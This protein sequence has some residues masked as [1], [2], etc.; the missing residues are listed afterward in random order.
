M[1]LRA[2]RRAVFLLKQCGGGKVGEIVE[3]VDQQ[4]L[5]KLPSML[6]SPARIRTFLGYAEDDK[7]IPTDEQMKRILSA[8]GMRLRDLAKSA[9]KQSQLL[10]EITPPSYR[11]DLD[12]WEAYAEEVG[13]IH[14]YDRIPARAPKVALDRSAPSPLLTEDRTRALLAARG[15]HEVINYSF[16]GEEERRSSPSA[17]NPIPIINPL[18][19][20]MAMMRCDLL[21]GLLR[22]LLH[23]HRQRKRSHKLFEFGMCFIPDKSKDLCRQ[24]TRLGGAILDMPEERLFGEPADDFYA[25]K[26]DLQA[27]FAACGPSN[28][29]VFS[30]DGEDSAPS[31]IHP[32]RCLFLIDGGNKRLGYAGQLHP[33]LHQ[34][35]KLDRAQVYVFEFMADAL[36]MRAVGAYEP[37]SRYP[38]AQFELALVMDHSISYHQLQ[39]Q[40]YRCVG[41]HLQEIELLDIY[42]SP[43]LGEGKKSIALRL[44]WQSPKETLTD[45]YVNGQMRQLLRQLEKQH[46]HLRS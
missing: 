27:L 31:T 34:Q 30:A 13:R 39:Q 23:N 1:P 32:G 14:G 45:E 10:W 24:E 46:I 21:P 15:Y 33:L 44:I 37:F 19:Q 42:T 5:P 12:C 18:S 16:I 9:G 6:A 4:H 20:A 8:L 26:S 41:E 36:N 2:I 17:T 11:F 40:I 38:I 28:S 43:K 7:D 35:Y 22:C 3:A 25:M 29:V